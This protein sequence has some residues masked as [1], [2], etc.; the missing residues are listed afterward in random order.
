M[1]RWKPPCKKAIRNLK[2][3]EAKNLVSDKPRLLEDVVSQYTMH[4]E[5][6][7]HL[8]AAGFVSEQLPAGRAATK[9]PE[10]EIDKVKTNAGDGNSFGRQC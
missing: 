2:V 6:E 10:I 4:S 9:S 1:S 5:R 3:K 8:A 7:T